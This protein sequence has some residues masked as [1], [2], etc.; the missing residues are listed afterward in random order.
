MYWGAS[1]QSIP[2]THTRCNKIFA[3]TMAGENHP[4]MSKVFLILET[5]PCFVSYHTEVA[6][7]LSIENG[8]SLEC[9]LTPSILV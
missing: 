9:H 7:L 5:S 1:S 6:H 3:F 8:S 2:A 4:S